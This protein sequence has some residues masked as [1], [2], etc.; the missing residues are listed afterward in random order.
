ML[1][2]V[3]SRSFAPH[4]HVASASSWASSFHHLHYLHTFG[5]TWCSCLCTWLRRYCF[6]HGFCLWSLCRWSLGWGYLRCRYRFRW[7]DPLVLGVSLAWTSCPAEDEVS[8]LTGVFGGGAFGV[9]R[10]LALACSAANPDKRKVSRAAASSFATPNGD[11]PN[12]ALLEPRGPQLRVQA[13]CSTQIQVQLT[14]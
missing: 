6:L 7:R 4:S 5:H 1:D 10:A 12:P 13:G 2:L 8:L 9:G 11:P 3:S 14:R